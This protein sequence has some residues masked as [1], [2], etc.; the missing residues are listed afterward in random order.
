MDNPARFL[1]T[2]RPSNGSCPACGDAVVPV[3]LTRLVQGATGLRAGAF[4]T[5]HWMCLDCRDA[6]HR[7]AAGSNSSLAIVPAVGS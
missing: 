1:F 4:T 6:D 5:L 3:T 7:A 2:D